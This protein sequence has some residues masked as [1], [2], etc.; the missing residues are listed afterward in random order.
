MR[1]R[2]IWEQ[3]GLTERD[4]SETLAFDVDPGMELR[5]QAIAVR[6]HKFWMAYGDL[7][8]PEFFGSPMAALFMRVVQEHAERLAPP[9]VVTARDL[10]RRS[11]LVTDDKREELIA[12]IDSVYNQPIMAVA[13]V[14]SAVVGMARKR[15]M[16]AAVVRIARLTEEYDDQT[17]E[18]AAVMQAALSMSSR[19]PNPVVSINKDAHLLPQWIAAYGRDAVPTLLPTLDRALRG[20]LLPGEL[21]FVLA[22]PNRGK[23]L[24]LV[25][26]AVCGMLSGRNVLY[27]S[28]EDGVSGIG[29]R[30]YTRLTGQPI[31]T[32]DG[33][34]SAT[35]TGL[36]KMLPFCHGELKL[37]YRP[38][39]RTGIMDL[40]TM[41]DRLEHAD[42]FSPHLIVIDYADRLK[43]PRKRKDQWLELSEGYTALM[44]FAAERHVA[45]WTASQAKASAFKKKQMDLDDIAGAFAKAAEAT[46]VLSYDQT[47]DE[48][49]AGE[50]RFR[51]AKMRNRK[52]GRVVHVYVNHDTCTLT[53]VPQGEIPLLV[54]TQRTTANAVKPA[55]AG[56]NPVPA[57]GS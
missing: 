52:K 8:Q 45:I 12:H 44:G 54:S 18:I 30:I 16:R 49:V 24:S 31:E 14:A 36:Q 27:V 1:G 26:F 23:S 3:I 7:L 28:L 56:P 53:E 11:P 13:Y 2:E 41:L 50:A 46:V 48:F 10:A 39:M 17:E 4:L 57:T 37:V 29:P 32:M 19:D 9:D 5:I 40:H 47:D 25:N 21:G 34:M 33:D 42:G 20:G 43:P 55:Q 35:L 6:D 22:P 38:P 15:A 51:A